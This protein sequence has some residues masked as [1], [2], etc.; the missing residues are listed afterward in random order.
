MQASYPITQQKNTNTSV[1]MVNSSAQKTANNIENDGYIFIYSDIIVPRRIGTKC[2]RVLKV[3]RPGNQRFFS[4]KNIE[5]IPLQ[6][7]F[8]DSM[9]ILITQADGKM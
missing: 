6:T 5:Y 3:L 4:F 2:N 7:N 8:F 9:S 1:Q